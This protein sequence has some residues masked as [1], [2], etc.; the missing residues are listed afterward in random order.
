MEFDVNPAA[1]VRPATTTRGKTSSIA[2]TLARTRN[3]IKMALYCRDIAEKKIIYVYNPSSVPGRRI[4]RII[5]LY[6]ARAG[7]LRP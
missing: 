3:V 5:I 4:K 7:S 2:T 1:R 6:E